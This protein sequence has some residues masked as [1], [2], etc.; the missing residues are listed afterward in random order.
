MGGR[1]TQTC[2]DL[3]L[4]YCG[5]SLRIQ[6][7]R[8]GVVIVIPATKSDLGI[9]QGRLSHTSRQTENQGP[10]SHKIQIF[11]MM[12]PGSGSAPADLQIWATDL[13]ILHFWDWEVLGKET[14]AIWKAT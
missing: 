14:A 4:K 5:A 3:I 11:R 12:I 13:A 10:A 2:T 8:P 6:V 7:L 9:G 1:Y